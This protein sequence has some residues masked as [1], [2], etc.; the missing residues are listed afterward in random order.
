MVDLDALLEGVADLVDFA[1]RDGVEVRVV[2][3]GRDL[4]VRVDPG[5]LE[6]AILNLCL[7]AGQA[8]EGPGEIRVE[9]SAHG[10]LAVIEV[11]DTGCGM[12]PAVLRHAMEPFYTARRDG[13]G[14]GL[15]LAMVYGFIRQSGGDVQIVSVE[16]QGTTVRLSLPLWTA[17]PCAGS[18]GSV[19][20]W[21]RVLLIEDDPA[22]MAAARAALD[23][24]GVDM[25]ACTTES[26]A[27][28]VLAG[29]ARFDLM[30][31]DLHLDGQPAGWDLAETALT[32]RP[33]LRVIVASGRLPAANPLERYGS[34]LVA[35]SKPLT[36]A[37]LMTAL[38]VPP[39]DP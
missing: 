25:V 8:M 12:S 10:N 29:S 15:G 28:D 35:V 6:S 9:A 20:A 39:H 22:A 24:P 31:T 32:T 26:G 4:T 1:L 7:N 27:R 3:S 21:T 33:A 16:G 2:P 34:R 38:A 14:T 13:T 11:T 23:G 37:V 17:P 5:Q 30:V 36:R 19:T 18:A